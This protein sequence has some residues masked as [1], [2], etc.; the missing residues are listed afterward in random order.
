MLCSFVS[1]FF[2]HFTTHHWNKK[3]DRLETS[4]RLK[5]IVWGLISEF[6]FRN[7]TQGHKINP[8][9]I[10]TGMRHP[11]SVSHTALSHCSWSEG[12]PTVALRGEPTNNSSD[13][14]SGG[15]G[16]NRTQCTV[17]SCEKMYI[18]FTIISINYHNR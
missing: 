12:M 13:D 4:T 16:R 9:F 6:F 11:I 15:S 3:C 1:F 7:L 14:R 18:L 10:E 8:I 17:S 5:I 2:F